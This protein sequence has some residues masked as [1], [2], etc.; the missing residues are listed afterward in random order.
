MPRLFLLIVN[1]L[2]KLI[3]S[4]I[5]LFKQVFPYLNAAKVYLDKSE[6]EKFSDCLLLQKLKAGQ[7]P[8][9]DRYIEYPWMME[10]IGIKQ[11]KLLDVGSTAGEMLASLLPSSIEIYG[12]NLNNKTIKN[13]NIK[14][15]VGDIRKT[16]FPDNY[17][18]V[19]TCVSTLEH[20]GV[21]GR[22]GSDNDPAGD[23]RAMSEIKRILKPSGQL[24]ATVPYGVKDVLPINKLYNK[25]K[26]ADLFSGLEIVHQEFKK[27]N[28]NRHVWLK[29]TETDAARTDMVKDG[30][31]A[32]CL[33]KAKKI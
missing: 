9:A 31:Y 23:L 22:Y 26:I 16:N 13:K 24:L 7:P 2:L 12:I 30:W 19:I 3:N 29:T 27:F 14:F 17:F 6:C 28:K 20:I 15:S 25:T 5:Y 10:N 18:D 8:A 21:N 4:L 33:I 1:F 11:G 32:L